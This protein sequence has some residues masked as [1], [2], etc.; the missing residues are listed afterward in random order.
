MSEVLKKFGK[1]FLL[2]LI[3]QGGMA[4]IYRARLAAQDG[5]GRLVVVKR[6]QAG[7]GANSEFL[8]MFK[9]EIKVTMGFNH[10]NIAQLYDFGEEQKQPYI[11][12]EL[13]DGKNVRQL[14]N[15]FKEL[16]QSFPIELAAYV[17][18]QAA[19][20]L[21]YA[22]SFRDKISGQPLNIVHRDISP[23]NI[24]V[25]YEGGVKIID[26]GIA[27]AT[28]NSEHTR[29]GVIK[30]KPS[31]LAPEQ[32]SGDAM[33]GRTDLFALGAVFWELLIGKKLF[34]GDNDLAVLKMIESCTT[35][36]RAPS[37]LNK[38]VPKELDAIVMKLLKKNPA[39]RFQTGEELSRALRRFL[40][41]YSPDFTP[42]DLALTAKELFNKEIVED[43]KKLQ[44]L[45]DRVEQLLLT[46]VQSHTTEEETG[47]RKEETTTFVS[48]QSKK[49]VEIEVKAED[50]A[51]QLRVEKPRERT[52]TGLT[53]NTSQQSGFYNAQANGTRASSYTHPSMRQGSQN[54]VE[55]DSGNSKWIALVASLALLFGGAWFGP[56]YGYEVPVLS[57]I[58]GAPI[59]SR[60]LG[61]VDAPIVAPV[62]PPIEDQNTKQVDFASPRAD[63]QKAKLK[64]NIFPAGKFGSVSVSGQKLDP[65]NTETTVDTDSLI[66]VS[67]NRPGFQ[68][69][70]SEF[71]IDSR[72]LGPNGEYVKEIN[73]EPEIDRSPAQA[74]CT[75]ECGSVTVRS[76]P[77]AEVSIFVN[78]KLF[79]KGYSPIERLQVPVGTASIRF[80]NQA[81]DLEDKKEVII[82]KSQPKI[83]NSDLKPRKH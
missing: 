11:T 38:N 75:G 67:I 12:M 40:M 52:K 8:Q 20:G 76:I 31:Y 81:L 14:L 13:I 28:T 73:L 79:K 39:E 47:V 53:R 19:Q 45:N 60:G 59:P 5:G 27:K 58:I 29:A 51:T 17:I 71:T 49:I 7:F 72:S 15:R 55:Q 80:V 35:T 1:Y 6:I 33:D 26:F 83:V 9:S 30:G 64:L 66:V 46:Q 74:V 18:E 77:S 43:R 62:Q 50:L 36:V 23:Q 78:G 54:A 44:R 69:F 48:K 41:Q 24:L 56:Q 63:V 3:A 61:S 22:H 70:N 4:E 25:S 65:A 16:N 37:E 32:I 21:Y 82:E 10:A 57:K 34:Q 42:N 2:D 68:P